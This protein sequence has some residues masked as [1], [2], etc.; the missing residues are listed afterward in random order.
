MKK[1][2]RILSMVLTVIL[3]VSAVALPVNAASS[4]YEDKVPWVPYGWRVAIYTA[5]NVKLFSFSKGGFTNQFINPTTYKYAQTF[6]QGITFYNDLASQCSATIGAT[7][8][9]VDGGVGTQI[10]NKYGIQAN[11][12]YS[13]YQE[14]STVVYPG[15]RV[16]VYADFYGTRIQGWG[17]LWA[18]IFTIKSGSIGVKI[19]NHVELR[20]VATN[21]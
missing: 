18:G 11:F 5:K 1:S 15:Q 3:V 2:N 4:D 7:T 14:I 21:P 6:S 19:P 12:Q 13:Y 9:I 17:K 8:G 10:N 16:T 20:L